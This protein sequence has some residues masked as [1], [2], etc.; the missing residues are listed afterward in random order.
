MGIRLARSIALQSFGASCALRSG[1]VALMTR[2]DVVTRGNII[3]TTDDDEEEVEDVGETVV[4]DAVIVGGIVAK[5]R[6]NLT[7]LFVD[8]G[9]APVVVD[10][11]ALMAWAVQGEIL[12]LG[13]DRTTPLSTAASAAVPEEE[14][15]E[16]EVMGISVDISV[17][18]FEAFNT[19]F[20]WS[21]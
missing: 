12:V 13:G 21:W 4:V 20:F 14:E 7:L 6:E 8:H 9:A 3:I 19:C 10:T 1:D 11:E 16:E 15:E 17:I 2:R 18:S 5:A